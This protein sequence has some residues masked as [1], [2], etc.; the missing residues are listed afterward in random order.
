MG[1]IV[2]LLHL[3]HLCPPEPVKALFFMPQNMAFYGPFFI[4][5]YTHKI[6]RRHRIRWRVGLG[7]L[8]QRRP[9]YGYQ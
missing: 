3:S 2:T 6:G 9:H 4:V 1:N 5:R 8:R 7:N